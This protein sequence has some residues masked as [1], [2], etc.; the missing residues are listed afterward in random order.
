MLIERMEKAGVDE[1]S[2]KDYVDGFKWG[3]PPHAGGG[4]GTSHISSPHSTVS[5]DH[6]LTFRRI[7]GLERLVML[8]FKLGDVRVANLF[9]RDPR[10]FPLVGKDQARMD[11]MIQGTKAV[12]HSRKD[13]QV[14]PNG[15]LP[16]L[17]AC[18]SN[19]S[20]STPSPRGG[21]SSAV[22]GDVS[23]SAMSAES[24]SFTVGGAGVE[25]NGGSSSSFSAFAGG[26]GG[27]PSQVEEGHKV[28][29]ALEG[30]TAGLPSP[31]STRPSSP[32]A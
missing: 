20:P 11:M 4:I 2:M 7:T 27:T 21:S 5:S 3:A 8:I 17:E 28:A 31:P 23:S 16:P 24:S 6:S 9:P 30:Y 18:V 15:E 13:P 29:P 1:N 12:P 22:G 25:N 14:G 19:S 32:S 26:R 10:S